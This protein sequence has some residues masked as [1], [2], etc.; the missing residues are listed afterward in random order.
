MKIP[1]IIE[2]GQF[3]KGK[4]SSTEYLL[5]YLIPS[6]LSS[7]CLSSLTIVFILNSSCGSGKQRDAR[8]NLQEY[9]FFLFNQTSKS[10][11][12]RVKRDI[13]DGNLCF[14]LLFYFFGRYGYKPLPLNIPK[15][16]FETNL[17][18]QEEDI[19]KSYISLYGD[20]DAL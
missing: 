14:I 1:L 2:H 5:F 16:I 4:K 11:I 20:V 12:Y 3:V 19:Q 6:Y 13:N 17:N 7:S 8:K 15:S 10:S 18:S 9:S